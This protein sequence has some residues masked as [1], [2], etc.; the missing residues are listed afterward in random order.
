MM[1][2]G[3][4]QTNQIQKCISHTP[5]TCN[6]YN[7]NCTYLL[8]SCTGVVSLTLSPS[9]GNILGGETIS[10]AGP[11]FS[12]TSRIECVFD[13][14][15]NSSIYVSQKEVLCIAPQLQRTGK[16]DFRLL[17]DET[18]KGRSQFTSSE[19]MNEV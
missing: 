15:R 16:V 9:Y 7:Y 2:G 14:I 12:P 4:R 6:Y 11:C 8:S 3:H 1:K 13:G 18:V 10:V 17:I 19:F 5:C